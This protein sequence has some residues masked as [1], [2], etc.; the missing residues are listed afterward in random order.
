L[1]GEAFILDSL[2]RCRCG[3]LDEAGALQMT[4]V[5]RALWWVIW[6]SGVVY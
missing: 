4:D 3:F 6:R 2:G 5:C 1:Y